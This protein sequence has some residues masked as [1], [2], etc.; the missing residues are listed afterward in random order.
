MHVRA[1][2]ELLLTIGSVC[3][4]VFLDFGDFLQLFYLIFPH[5]VP[6]VRVEKILFLF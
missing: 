3:L 2:Q 5:L 6:R 1:Q 4:Y